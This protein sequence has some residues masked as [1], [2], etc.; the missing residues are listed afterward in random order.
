MMV[1]AKMDQPLNKHG[2]STIGDAPLR[3]LVADDHALFRAGLRHLLADF[4]D[5]LQIEE[6]HDFDNTAARLSEVD[7]LD[8]LLLDLNMPGMR[9]I[10]SVEDLCARAPDVPIIVISVRETPD[11]VRKAIDAGAM[12][13]IP[14]SSTPE[15]MMSALQLVLSGGIYLPPHLLQELPA[16]GGPAGK[17]G[18]SESDDQL[19]RLTP[20]QRDVLRLLAQGQSN[21]QIA[22]V[23]GL[24]PGTVKI[25]ISRILRAF[26]VQNRTQ[27]VIAASEA[28]GES[29][30]EFG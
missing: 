17:N 3:I 10:S 26:K 27:A 8:L 16:G 30:T 29:K 21:K 24:A 28:L 7:D 23:L 1:S 13:Y 2:A 9:G 19:A 14:K 18:S 11:D 15:V 20:R 12:G 22:D 25:H 6:A 4:G 5:R